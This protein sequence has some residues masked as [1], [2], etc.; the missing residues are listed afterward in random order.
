M[1]LLL[2]ALFCSLVVIVLVP[3][4]VWHALWILGG[5]LLFGTIAYW[6]FIFFIIQYE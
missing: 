3:N 1:E 6:S 5:I 2:L 4:E